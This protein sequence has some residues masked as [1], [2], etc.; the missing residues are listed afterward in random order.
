MTDTIYHRSASSFQLGTAPGDGDVFGSSDDGASAMPSFVPGNTYAATRTDKDNEDDAVRA[1][2]ANELLLLSREKRLPVPVAICGSDNN[3]G[4][5]G[6][7]EPRDSG[8]RGHSASTY[9]PSSTTHSLVPRTAHREASRYHVGG[10]DAQAFYSP[11][12]CVFVAK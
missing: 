12:A 10:V 8:S 7:P 2:P 9:M 11:D 5:I 6:S 4:L 1:D 3:D